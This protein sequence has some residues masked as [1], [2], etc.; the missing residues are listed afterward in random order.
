MTYRSGEV[1]KAGDRVTYTS[2]PGEVEFV[3]TE[4]VVDPAQEWGTTWVGESN[5]LMIVTG[6][7]GRVFLQPSDEDL[8]FVSRKPVL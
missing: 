1:P 4:G 6:S 8:E 7:M 2:E 5:G 3:V